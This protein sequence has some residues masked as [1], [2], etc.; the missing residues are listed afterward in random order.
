MVNWNQIDAD[1]IECR[2]CVCATKLTVYYECLNSNC[3]MTQ[4]DRSGEGCRGGAWLKESHVDGNVKP[5][6]KQKSLWLCCNYKRKAAA[7]WPWQR[8]GAS[9]GGRVIVS[10]SATVFTVT[11]TVAHT[12]TTAVELCVRICICKCN[13]ICNGHLASKASVRL[14]V[15]SVRTI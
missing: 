3:A 1:R 2:H 10:V 11:I 15:P 4:A 9:A 7:W 8:P 12:C 14:S 6:C 13:Q 5:K